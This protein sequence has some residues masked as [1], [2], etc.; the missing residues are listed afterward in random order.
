MYKAGPGVEGVYNAPQENIDASAYPTY[1]QSPAS[2]W[3]TCSNNMTSSNITSTVDFHGSQAW[4]NASV[5]DGS[6]LFAM[7]GNIPSKPTSHLMVTEYIDAKK[8]VQLDE[9]HWFFDFGTDF[10]GG[11]HLELPAGIAYS[12][13]SFVLTLSEELV[14]NFSDYLFATLDSMSSC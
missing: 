5:A 6:V 13:L 1:C 9:G 3:G 11:I 10:M 12:G 4:V 7:K 14:G 8:V 2:T